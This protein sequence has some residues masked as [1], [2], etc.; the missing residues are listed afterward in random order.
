MRQPVDRCGRGAGPRA[1][2]I[3]PLGDCA[4]HCLAGFGTA[5]GVAVLG[6][7]APAKL[8][9]PARADMCPTYYR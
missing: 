1:A 3:C 8:S 2:S 4:Y 5:D 6:A 7:S 9:K